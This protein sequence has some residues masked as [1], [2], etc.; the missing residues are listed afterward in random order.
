[1]EL[2][3]QK[4]AM[5]AGREGRVQSA[6]LAVLQIPTVSLRVVVGVVVLNYL[7]EAM[8]EWVE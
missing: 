2:V 7:T 6:D 8:V 3:Q 4:S 5:L 1:V